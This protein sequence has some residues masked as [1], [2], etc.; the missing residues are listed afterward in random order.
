MTPIHRYFRDLYLG[1]WTTLVGM[2]VTFR[3]LFMPTITVQ[4]PHQ[5]LKYPERA[6]AALVNNIDICNGCAQCARAC[7]VDIIHIQT[8]KALKEE[9]LGL[10]PDGKPKRLHVVRFD[11]DMSKC[12]FC[13]LCVDACPTGAIHWE[14]PHQPVFFSRS[15]AWKRWS[16]YSAEDRKRLLER[17]AAA[18][19]A[20]AAAPSAHTAAPA[21]PKESTLTA[22]A[23]K[24]AAPRIIPIEGKKEENE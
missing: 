5:T 24:D 19:A 21:A 22:D 6:R 12:V 4:Y 20:K 15:E 2:K 7:P 14:S 18:K 17:D 23:P 13:G 10:L 9:D 11:V 3:H 1:V 8:V 16:K